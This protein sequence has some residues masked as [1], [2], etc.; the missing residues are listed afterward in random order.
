MI[1]KRSVR[2]GLMHKE[3][4]T[5]FREPKH[6]FSY[7]SIALAMPFMVYCCYTLFDTL[8]YNAFSIKFGFG[9]ALMVILVFTILTN[10]FCA[11]N[12]TRDGISAL[13]AKIFPVKASKILSAKVR[14]CFIISSLSVIASAAVLYFF[15]GL[16]LN[17]V[18]LAMGIGIIF[19]LSQ[20]MIATKMDLKHAVLTASAEEIAKSS[21][22]TIAKVITVG[23]FFALLIGIVTLFISLFVGKTPSFLGGFEIKQSY[24]QLAPLTIAGRYFIFSWIYYSVG[25][26]KAFHKLVR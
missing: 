5:V 7:F 16:K 26:E 11:T 1:V 12:V 23:L 24:R 6:M 20:I 8:L 21:N 25:T 3:F 22:R 2:G 13:K 15:V 4:I 14:F 17:D 10:T 9:L 18:L 19:S